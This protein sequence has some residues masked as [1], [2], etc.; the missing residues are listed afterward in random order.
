MEVLLASFDAFS[1][2]YK[3]IND[4]RKLLFGKNI[5]Y[6]L[7]KFVNNF[8]STTTIFHKKYSCDLF[9]ML[10]LIIC[11]K[12]LLA[13]LEKQQINHSILCIHRL[14]CGKNVLTALCKSNSRHFQ[15]DSNTNTYF[16]FV[17]VTFDFLALIFKYPY[18]CVC[19]YCLYTFLL[20]IEMQISVNCYLYKLLGIQ[21]I[22]PWAQIYALLHRP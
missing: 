12:I 8:N 13:K 16:Y 3:T 17:L 1:K 7:I 14:I 11:F 22:F 4:K 21:N 9:K 20:F 10:I 2:K 19:L 5:C 15:N 18:H 6:V